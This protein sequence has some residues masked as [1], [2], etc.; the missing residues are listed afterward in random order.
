M[1]KQWVSLVAVIGC[2]ALASACSNDEA[3][4]AARPNTVLAADSDITKVTPKDD[5]LYVAAK[6]D[7]DSSG[8]IQADAITR[9]V[10]D[11]VKNG[12]DD[13]PA[14]VK[15]VVIDLQADVV[16]NYGNNS[17][18]TMLQL[19]YDV[20]DMKR[21]NYDG[22]GSN[23]FLNAATYAQVK[24]TSFGSVVSDSCTNYTVLYHTFCQN[25]IS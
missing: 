6:I 10:G 23:P 21:T 12:A 9:A 7:G 11:A 1:L 13:V 20:N 4:E 15:D 2:A 17:K 5:K 19:V 24:N 25:L 8:L 22:L 3:V 16:D 14:G 18:A